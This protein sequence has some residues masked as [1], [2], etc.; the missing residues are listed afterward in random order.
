MIETSSVGSNAAVHIKLDGK[1]ASSEQVSTTSTLVQLAAI[2]LLFA[3]MLVC[4]FLSLPSFKDEKETSEI[5]TL[6]RSLQQVK[7]M[8]H[9]LSSYT[10]HS[11]SRVL[12]AIFS[13]YIFLQTFSVPG[14]IF[15]NVLC[16]AL[17]GLPVAFCV[18]LIVRSP[19][20][21]FNGIH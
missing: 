12:F 11:Y 18:T 19:Y 1:H 4:V 3:V 9:I 14:T 16:G 21:N 20:G 7:S 8:A 15:L 6:P 5:L 10:Q 2:F 13:L 17:F